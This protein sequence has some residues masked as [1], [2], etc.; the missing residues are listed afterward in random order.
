MRKFFI[1]MLFLL[2]SSINFC[3]GIFVYLYPTNCIEKKGETIALIIEEKEGFEVLS[4][5]LEGQVEYPIYRIGS[6]MVYSLVG[7]PHTIVT[8]FMLSV[9]SIDRLTGEM[10]VAEIPFRVNIDPIAY[11]KRR[12]K[13]IGEIEIRNDL[14]FKTNKFKLLANYGGEISVFSKPLEGQVKDGY[15]VNRSRGGILHG[16]IHLG[17]DI[18]RE[19][20]AKV[21][22]A[23]DGVVIS[24]ARDRKAGKYVVIQHGY[25]VCSVYMHLS[26]ILVKRGQVVTTNTVIGLV[27]ATGRTTGAHLHFGISVNNIYVDPLSFLERDY[28]PQSVISNGT[29]IKIYNL[30]RE[31]SSNLLVSQ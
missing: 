29:K 18:P 24:T 4:V 9:R 16:R 22:S 20:G 14:S 27:G 11:A 13:Q 25:G 5:A 6:N 10:L 7:L 31:A 1:L 23:Y 26:E 2:L 15:G 19:W 21:Y 12:P 8:N 3:Y 17:V 28:S 30:N